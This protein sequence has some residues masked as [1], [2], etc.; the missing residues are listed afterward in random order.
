MSTSV[1]QRYMA[2]DQRFAS[3]RADVLAYVT[4]PLDDDVTIAGPVS[5]K[6]RISSTGTDSDFVVK[7]I[8]VYPNDYPEDE[9]VNGGKRVLGAPSVRMGGYQQ[10]L[11]GDRCARSSEIA[12][13]N[14]RRWRQVNGGA[15][16]FDARR[17]SHFPS[18]APDYGA[19]PKFVV[20]TYR[21]QSTIVCGDS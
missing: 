6:L 4:E 21:P 2:D 14:Q 17:G 10:L 9:S 3:R 15:E 5:P 13:R 7:L 20:P 18:R 11:R 12:G 8:D 19:N 16:F 1:P